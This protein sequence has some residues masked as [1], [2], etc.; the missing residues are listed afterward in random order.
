MKLPELLPPTE[1]LS[2]GAFPGWVRERG[3]AVVESYHGGWERPWR[4]LDRHGWNALLCECGRDVRAAVMETGRCR[5]FAVRYGLEVIPAVLVFQDGEVIARFTGKVEV[6]AV[7]EALKTSAA[8]A[9]T[10][11]RD[12]AELETVAAAAREA[13]EVAAEPVP[14]ETERL[15]PIPAPRRPRQTSRQGS[16]RPQLSGGGLRVGPRVSMTPKY[17]FAY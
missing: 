14:V 17:R 2:D 10:L 3:A 12:L 5:E 11:K 6:R 16:Q 7:I 9:H 8:R 1:T 13:V 4:A 15:V